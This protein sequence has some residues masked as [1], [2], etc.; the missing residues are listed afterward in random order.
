FFS[1]ASCGAL[2]STATINGGTNTTTVY[3]KDNTAQSTQLTA[4][5]TG[6]SAGNLSVVV[7]PGAPAALVLSGPPSVTASACATFTVTSEDSVGNQSP[8]SSNTFVALTGAGSGTFFTDAGCTISAAGGVDITTG[9]NS[10]T[11]YFQDTVPQSLTFNA[12]SPPLIA[13]NLPV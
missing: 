2:T 1:N 8:V 7:D 13:G 4:S 5:V 10:Q 3:F 6:L 11:F 12:A 9:N